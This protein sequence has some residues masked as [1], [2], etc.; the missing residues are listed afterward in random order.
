ML[1]QIGWT[2]GSKAT[3]TKLDATTAGTSENII[4]TATSGQIDYLTKRFLT[5][6]L[7]LP[8]ISEF[9]YSVDISQNPSQ[10]VRYLTRFKSQR[11][12]IFKWK[13]GEQNET[14]STLNAF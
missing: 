6:S 9:I 14:R 8:V 12:S 7:S 11:R 5:I 2:C 4:I 13:I 10:R 3:W 1:H